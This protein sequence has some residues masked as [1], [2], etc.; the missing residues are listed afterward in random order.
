M[1]IKTYIKVPEDRIHIFRANLAT[2]NMEYNFLSI[3]EVSNKKGKYLLKNTK[4][5]G[6]TEVELIKALRKTLSYLLTGVI[7]PE[8][9]QLEEVSTL[10]CT[11]R[12]ISMLDQS[13]YSECE[14]SFV[15]S[16]NDSYF[17]RL[18]A[19]KLFTF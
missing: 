18:K 6:F 17:R 13:E 3:D 11:S 14:P 8:L 1:R 9:A 7:E 10:G 5:M 2:L 15:T 19:V 12:E 16:A 4:T